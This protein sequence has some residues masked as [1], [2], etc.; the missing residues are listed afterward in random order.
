MTAPRR[1]AGL[2]LLGLMALAQSGCLA[3]VAGVA[4]AG[5][6]AGYVYYNGLIAR[7]YRAK[8][9]ETLPVVRTALLSQKFPIERET[10]ELGSATI[11]SR[12]SDGHTIRVH[13]DVIPGPAPGDGTV[14]RVGVRVGFGG[15]DAISARI[16]DEITRQ[17]PPS[18]LAPQGEPGSPI[19]AA[20]PPGQPNPANTQPLPQ[21]PPPAQTTPPPL[22][23]SP[24]GVDKN[25]KLVPIPAGSTR[26][27]R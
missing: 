24:A 14:T 20:V 10:S 25:G 18:A 22:A 19:V 3:A 9:P 13:L 11:Y 5:A 27:I 6:V 12:T 23:T 17:M 15:D 4:G 2:I 1:T 26:P 8:L 7:D 16:L 21:T